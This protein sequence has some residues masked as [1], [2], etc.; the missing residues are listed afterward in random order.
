M[1]VCMHMHEA[2][3][4][5]PSWR[6]RMA[7]QADNNRAPGAGGRSNSTGRGVQ[8]KLPNS[9]AGGSTAV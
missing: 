7:R 6:L 3:G 1:Y 5:G 4:D 2:T 8:Q 9:W